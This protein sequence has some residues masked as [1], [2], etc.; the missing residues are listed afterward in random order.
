VI[1]RFQWRVSPYRR[2]TERRGTERKSQMPPVPLRFLEHIPYSKI[3]SM[4]SI[5]QIYLPVLN[6]K[7]K[8]IRR[9]LALT[10]RVCDFEHYLQIVCC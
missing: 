5:S 3:S 8:S 6:T 2:V 4:R 1:L 10:L 9:I 7:D